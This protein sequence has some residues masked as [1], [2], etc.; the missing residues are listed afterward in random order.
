[1]ARDY[2]IAAAEDGS[3][4]WVYRGRLPRELNVP[5]EPHW[6]LQGRLARG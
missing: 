2:F 6:F 5:G 3:L 1:M 4:V